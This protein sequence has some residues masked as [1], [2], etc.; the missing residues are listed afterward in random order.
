[1]SLEYLL[2]RLAIQDTITRGCTAIDT[3]TPDLFDQVFTP[4]AVVD[5]SPLVDPMDYPGFRRWSQAWVDGAAANFHGWQHLLSNMVVEID[6][7]TASASTDFYNP[8]VAN[9]QSVIHSYGRYHDRL[10]RTAAGWRI[11]HRKTQ[12]LRNPDPTSVG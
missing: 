1:M 11:A 2:D 5:Y 7:D 12:A 6:G 10:V 9:D 3:R 8:L 4:D